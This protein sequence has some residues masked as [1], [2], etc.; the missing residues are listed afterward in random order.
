[1]NGTGGGSSGQPGGSGGGGRKKGSSKQLTQMQQTSRRVTRSSSR[2]SAASNTGGSPGVTPPPRPT[3]TPP[4]S[5]TTQPTSFAPPPLALLHTPFPPSSVSPATLVPPQPLLSPMPLNSPTVPPL[6]PMPPLQG[7]G[8]GGTHTTTTTTTTSPS[9]LSP[10]LSSPPPPPT[11]SPMPKYSASSDK[12]LTASQSSS[13]GFRPLGTDKVVQAKPIDEGEFRFPSNPTQSGHS[14]GYH[15]SFGT[16]DT[17]RMLSRRKVK[18]GGKA[19][20]PSWNTNTALTG[21]SGASILETNVKPVAE[22]SDGARTD[23]AQTILSVPGGKSA[24]HTGSG[25]KTTG[26]AQAHDFLRHQVVRTLQEP[27]VTPGVAGV[28]AGSITLMSIAPGQIANTAQNADKLKD[29]GVSTQ[30]EQRRNNGKRKL[31]EYFDALSPN[32]QATVLKL[33]QQGMSDLKDKKRKLIPGRPHSPL[34]EEQSSPGASISG[35]GYL[36][37]VSVPTTPSLAFP[38][39]PATASPGTQPLP[40]F[41]SLPPLSSSSV[42]TPQVPTHAF[43]PIV[44]VTPSNPTVPSTTTTTTTTPQPSN[45]APRDVAMDITSYFRSKRQ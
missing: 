37:P 35:G 4:V 28:L 34:R 8:T 33:T 32:E 24:G 42:P 9:L 1:M 6:S 44:P 31:D 45:L 29:S 20:L 18:K 2:A 36:P 41:H 39:L 5:T 21:Y 22:A 12:T 13:G 17:M 43:Q 19:E 30:Y 7:G 27:G 40:V 3:L 23:T 14:S 10:M 16:T 26:Q 15:E 11:L 38:T 25:V